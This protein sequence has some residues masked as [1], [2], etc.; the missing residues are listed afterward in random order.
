MSGEREFFEDEDPTPAEVDAF[1]EPV[2][3]GADAPEPEPEVVE[4][5][6]INT[7]IPLS[8][9]VESAKAEGLAGYPTEDPGDPDVMWSPSPG[10]IGCHRL[11]FRK[12]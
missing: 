5:K 6:K 4:A 9:H 12:V 10:M 3:E 1:L 8:L 2:V 7:K 11:G